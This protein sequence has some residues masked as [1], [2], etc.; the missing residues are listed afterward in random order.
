MP[1]GYFTDKAA[2]YLARAGAP[3]ADTTPLATWAQH[4]KESGE[5]ITNPRAIVAEDGQVVATATRKGRPNGVQAWY[6]DRTPETEA[7]GVAGQV[8]DMSLGTIKRAVGQRVIE[9]A[10]ADVCRGQGV[11]RTM[12]ADSIAELEA[13]VRE[14]DERREV[15]DAAEK[16]FHLEI[17]RRAGLPGANINRIS[18]MVG[19][20]RQTIYTWKQAYDTLA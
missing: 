3:D 8:T 17:G 19:V 4:V 12:S 10:A 15:F 6:I 2:D 1:H 16:E 7:W 5:H 18:R 13:L 20:A 14:R 11:R 9:V